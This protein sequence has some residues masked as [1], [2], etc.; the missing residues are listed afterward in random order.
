MWSCIQQVACET[1]SLNKNLLC[2]VHELKWAIPEFT[3]EFICNALILTRVTCFHVKS[4]PSGG[5]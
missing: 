5:A 4:S 1:V 3:W 2:F